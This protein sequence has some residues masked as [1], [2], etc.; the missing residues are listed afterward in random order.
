M[1]NNEKPSPEGNSTTNDIEEKSRRGERKKSGDTG[2]RTKSLDGLISWLVSH[3]AVIN[4]VEE[5]NVPGK[6]FTILT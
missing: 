2:K 1:L 4:S 5:R 6:H 3:D